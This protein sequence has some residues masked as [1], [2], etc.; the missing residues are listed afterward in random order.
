MESRATQL[1]GLLIYLVGV[2]LSLSQSLQAT[3][4]D[5]FTYAEEE[6][7][8]VAPLVQNHFKTIIERLG[9]QREQSDP[10][11][12]DVLMFSR[13]YKKNELKNNYFSSF[14]SCVLYENCVGWIGL[15]RLF[16]DPRQSVYGRSDYDFFT[17]QY[18]SPT[19]NVCGIKIGADKLTHMFNDGFRMFEIWSWSN[20][21]LKDWNIA[22]KSLKE[23][24]G[25]M[26]GISSRVISFSDVQANLAGLRLFRDLFFGPK[27]LERRPNDSGWTLS[28]RF[29]L[30]RYI[31]PFLNE[32]NSVL[33]FVGENAPR[34]LV[35]IQ[36]AP[37]RFSSSAER[38]KGLSK[39]GYFNLGV[40]D[41]YETI[42]RFLLHP[43]MVSDVIEN[44]FDYSP[45][46]EL[47]ILDDRF[48]TE[49]GLHAIRQT[50]VEPTSV[51]HLFPMDSEQC[52]C[53]TAKFLKME[54]V[55]DSLEKLG[56]GLLRCRVFYYGKA[57]SEK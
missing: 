52:R 19:I 57:G 32:K 9:S 53:A 17:T 44:F 22:L 11:Q 54:N 30:C 38:E 4:T 39:Q 3:E 28:Q 55:S 41:Y 5:A 23:E 36:N 50:T 25:I 10:S 2:L 31:N 40:R 46:P 37:Q 51:C 6:L 27:Y 1:R 45:P 29:D 35:Q 49:N 16:L 20:K 12:P 18:L 43:L 8:D 48:Q 14:E 21:N 34:L 33:L 7:R 26:G 13:L 42:K 56:R 24:L 47:R 15:Q